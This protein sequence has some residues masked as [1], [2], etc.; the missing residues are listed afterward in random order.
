MLCVKETNLH[1][2]IIAEHSQVILR[3][4]GGTGHNIRQCQHY[5]SVIGCL[6][7]DTYTPTHIMTYMVTHT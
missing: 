3:T 5:I 2:L 6:K 1:C 4:P 7:T